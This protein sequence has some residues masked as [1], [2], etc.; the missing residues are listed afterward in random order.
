[1]TV[2]R[3]RR[4]AMDT[5]RTGPSTHEWRRLAWAIAFFAA[6][7]AAISVLFAIGFYH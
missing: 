3:T 4:E 6:C 7:L 1:M 2:Q 5:E